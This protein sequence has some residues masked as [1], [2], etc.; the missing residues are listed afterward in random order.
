MADTTSQPPSLAQLRARRS[1]IV[2]AASARGLVNLRVFGSVARGEGAPGSD[3]DIVVDL[4]KG[5]RGFDAFGML[6]EFRQD[7]EVL[8]GHPVNV[9]TVRGPFSERGAEIARRIQQEALIL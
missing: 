9:V 2:R 8:L 1:D 4:P 5:A 7:L 6:D 3:I